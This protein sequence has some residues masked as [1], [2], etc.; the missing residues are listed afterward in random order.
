MSYDTISKILSAVEREMPEAVLRTDPRVKG[1]CGV[2][3]R[4]LASMDSVGEGPRERVLIGRQVAYPKGAPLEWIAG[5][6]RAA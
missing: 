1:W 3:A 5:R 4:R 6:L 2:G